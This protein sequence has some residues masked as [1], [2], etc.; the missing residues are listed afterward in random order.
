MITSQLLIH[1]LLS[2]ASMNPFAKFIL[3][4]PNGTCILIKTTYGGHC[5]VVPVAIIH[6]IV[7]KNFE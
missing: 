2:A 6:L 1:Y 4:W 3:Q 5:F 7:A